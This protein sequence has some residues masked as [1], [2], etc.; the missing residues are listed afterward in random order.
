MAKSAAAAAGSTGSAGWTAGRGR[1]ARAGGAVSLA[2]AAAASARARRARPGVAHLRRRRPAARSL[3][4]PM[5]MSRGASPAP[6]MPQAPGISEAQSCPRLNAP[7]WGTRVLPG[8]R[9]LRAVLAGGFPWRPFWGRRP[10]C[11]RAAG[12]Q[13]AA[14]DPFRIAA[15][16]S[17]RERGLTS[18]WLEEDPSIGCSLAAGRAPA[19]AWEARFDGHLRTA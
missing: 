17:D 8:A 6:S 19:R 2:G 12:E 15:S 16:I 7:G 11:P 1:G 14:M 4:S 10:P 18:I 3:L 5:P 13:P 9:R